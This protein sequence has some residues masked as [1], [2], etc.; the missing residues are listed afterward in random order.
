MEVN[1]R[2]CDAAVPGLMLWCDASDFWSLHDP[3]FSL[4]SPC[5]RVCIEAKLSNSRR[6]S[7]FAS[8][9]VQL[10]TVNASSTTSG[11]LFLSPQSVLLTAAERMNGR[12]S[13]SHESSIW[14]MCVGGDL[15]PAPS[16]HV[17]AHAHLWDINNAWTSLASS[18]LDWRAPHPCM[19]WQ[20]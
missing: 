19:T 11:I 1:A 6:S 20:I 17:S 9:A 2:I 8:G 18:L 14:G 10:Q 3:T 5:I 4:S 15:P 12:R 13:V 16:I 7:Y